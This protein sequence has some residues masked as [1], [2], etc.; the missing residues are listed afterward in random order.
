MGD[1]DDLTSVTAVLDDEYARSILAA[2][3]REA[4]G[5]AE[6]AERIDADVSTVYRRLDRLES[7]DLVTTRIDLRQDGHHA[8]RYR[9]QLRRVTVELR[10][11]EFHVAVERASDDPAD[12]LTDLFE[13]LR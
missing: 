8:K 6:L 5:A 13:E 3:S 9:A 11:G 1:G 7:L 10:D 12:R 2:T 4:L